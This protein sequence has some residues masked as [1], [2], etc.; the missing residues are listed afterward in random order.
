LKDPEHE[1]YKS[2]LRDFSDF[3]F[4]CIML[5]CEVYAGNCYSML[6]A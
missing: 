1:Q 3:N 2:I 5:H 4:V 6:Y